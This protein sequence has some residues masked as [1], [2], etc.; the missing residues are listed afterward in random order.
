[1][2]LRVKHNIATYD[3]DIPENATLGTTVLS[4]ARNITGRAGIRLRGSG[5]DLDSYEK[6]ILHFAYHSLEMKRLYNIGLRLC[7][8]YLPIQ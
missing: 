3:V 2:N 5:S 4:V 6:N 1:M 7:S 8:V